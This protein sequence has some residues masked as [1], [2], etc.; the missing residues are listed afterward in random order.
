MTEVLG[1]SVGVEAVSRTQIPS[2]AN[3]S[4]T[5]EVIFSNHSD[6]FKNWQNS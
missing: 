1:C 4:D 2:D 3:D 6:Q 5:F